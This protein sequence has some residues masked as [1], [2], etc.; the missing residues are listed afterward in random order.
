VVSRLI[1]AIAILQQQLA[2]EKASRQKAE[3]F[4]QQEQKRTNEEIHELRDKLEKANEENKAN[5]ENK[6]NEENSKNGE[7]WCA[8]L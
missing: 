5:K 6:A 8:I 4:A 1:E 2:E 3:E 7:K